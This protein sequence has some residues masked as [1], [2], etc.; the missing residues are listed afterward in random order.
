M[1]LSC[2]FVE[3]ALVFL[4]LTV[5]WQRWSGSRAIRRMFNITRE[6]GLASLFAVVQTFVVAVVCWCIFAVV[7]KNDRPRFQRFGW[8]FLA[9]L[10]SYMAIDDGAAVHERVG[11]AFKHANVVTG[12]PSYA[13]Q[14]IFVPIFAASGLF[15][16]LFLW[17]V[18]SYSKFRWSIVVATG[19]FTFAVVLD[20]FEGLEEGYTWLVNQFG[21]SAKTI[22]HFSKSAEEFIEM[23]GMTILLV[24]FLN[25]IANIGNTITIQFNSE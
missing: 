19:C 22:K 25:H 15:M 16:L 21:W 6:D 11:T 18:L 20:Y 12:F 23:L 2:L 24:S 7:R 17:R 5:N 4:D 1:F 9:V 13:W 14:L 3:I 8:L 10:F